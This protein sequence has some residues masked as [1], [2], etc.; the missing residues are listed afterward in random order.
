[1]EKTEEIHLQDGGESKTNELL[2]KLSSMREKWARTAVFLKA[3]YLLALTA[4]LLF[5]QYAAI[6]LQVFA[7]ILAVGFGLWIFSAFIKGRFMPSTRR[8]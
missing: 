8:D 5:G 3:F 4:L 1:M 6:E 7:A 2:L